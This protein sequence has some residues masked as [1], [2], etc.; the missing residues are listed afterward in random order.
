MASQEIKEFE[1]T[2]KVSMD[3]HLQH[4]HNGPIIVN[5][6]GFPADLRYPCFVLVCKSYLSENAE[7][8][9]FFLFLVNYQLPITYL[10]QAFAFIANVPADTLWTDSF[11]SGRGV[12]EDSPVEC[13]ESMYGNALSPYH[14]LKCLLLNDHCDP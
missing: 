1:I 10:K 9:Q 13:L 6:T 3:Y 11:T 2:K 12:T 4:D 7:K 14:L 8:T 5:V